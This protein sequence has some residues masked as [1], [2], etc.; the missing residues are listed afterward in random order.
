MLESG[1]SNRVFAADSSLNTGEDSMG[2]I[3]VVED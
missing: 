2:V 3:G 1:D